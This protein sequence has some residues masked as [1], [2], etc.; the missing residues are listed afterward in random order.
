MTVTVVMV[1][2]LM[3]QC[4]CGGFV[5]VTVVSVHCYC[6]DGVIVTAMTVSLLLW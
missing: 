6:S 4:Y 2:L 3:W 5:I 1:S